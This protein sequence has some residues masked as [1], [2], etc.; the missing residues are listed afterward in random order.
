MY[1]LFIILQIE[2]VELNEVLNIL[3]KYNVMLF[4]RK[5]LIED[6]FGL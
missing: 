5:S 6:M 1:L 2:L 4:R 3:F